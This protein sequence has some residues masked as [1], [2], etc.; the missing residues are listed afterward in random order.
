[1]YSISLK[2]WNTYRWGPRNIPAGRE[3]PCWGRSRGCTEGCRSR[4]SRRRS[5]CSR[6]SRRQWGRDAWKLPGWRTE[7]EQGPILDHIDKFGNWCCKTSMG[8]NYYWFYYILYSNLSINKYSVSFVKLQLR[9][10]NGGK[11]HYGLYGIHSTNPQINHSTTIF[12]YKPKYSF[13]GTLNYTEA[14]TKLYLFV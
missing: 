7:A 11:L 5:G 6:Q 10:K 8:S 1:M 13:C 14:I 9:K 2:S 12:S 3:N 4:G